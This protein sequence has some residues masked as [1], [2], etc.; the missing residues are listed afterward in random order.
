MVIPTGGRATYVYDGSDA[1]HSLATY[2]GTTRHFQYW[3]RDPVAGGASLDTSDAF[4]ILI[5]P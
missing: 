5:T 4:S 1:P 2:A 3:Y